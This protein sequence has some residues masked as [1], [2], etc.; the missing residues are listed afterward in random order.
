M[1]KIK[2]ARK[3][4]RIDMTPMVDLAFLLLTFFIL[5]VKFRA[6]DAV[7]VVI[8][9]SIAETPLPQQNIAI[10]TVAPDG[11][12]F[13]GIDSKH[14]RAEMLKKIADYYE[15]EFTP[16]QIEAFSVLPNFGLPLRKLPIYLDKT[17][18]ER[19]M[20][21][22]EGI[23]VDSTKN[24]LKD[25]IVA[26]RLSN[27]KLRFAIKADKN[28]PYPAIE[29]VI[30]TLRDKKVNRFALITSQEA[31]PDELKTKK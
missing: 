13:F 22:P 18:A 24:E 6:P 5:T 2:T 27:P 11:R 1:T 7:E 23:P 25:W 8:P 12:V 20:Y 17:P 16:E 26:A 31:L 29:K 19:E 30:N 3:S 9:S 10:I 21:I 15:L 4:T 14:D 28:T